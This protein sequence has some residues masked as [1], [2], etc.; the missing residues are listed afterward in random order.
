MAPMAWGNRSKLSLP[1]AREHLKQVALYNNGQIWAAPVSVI[2]GILQTEIVF[3][4]I[5]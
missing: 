2:P 1:L 4:C 5:D 3:G